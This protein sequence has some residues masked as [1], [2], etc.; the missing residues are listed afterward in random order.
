M[1]YL[2]LYYFYVFVLIWVLVKQNSISYY[3]KTHRPVSGQPSLRK[4]NYVNFLVLK[5]VY[6]VKAGT[7]LEK[8]VL[9]VSVGNDQRHTAHWFTK[10]TQSATHWVDS[11]ES[12]RFWWLIF[13]LVLVSAGPFT[14]EF[15]EIKRSRVLI[16]SFFL[17]FFVVVV[18]LLF[19]FFLQMS[20]GGLRHWVQLVWSSQRKLHLWQNKFKKHNFH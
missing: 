10:M 19:C 4:K 11:V 16:I 9:H 13:A 1:V 7:F 3:F 12:M 20:P 8:H 6:F 17:F 14:W 15:S 2:Y 18:L 5:L